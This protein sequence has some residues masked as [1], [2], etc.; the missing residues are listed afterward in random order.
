MQYK[1]SVLIPRSSLE[2]VGEVEVGK[3]YALQL[4]EDFLYQFVHIL[5]T[6]E[7]TFT[8]ETIYVGPLYL[9]DH[10][11]IA[12]A[13]FIKKKEITSS[14]FRQAIDL[15]EN[16]KNEI[17]SMEF[18]KTPHSGK[19][20]VGHYYYFT[21][22]PGN[23]IT[24]GYMSSFDSGGTPLIQAIEV[25]TFEN[26]I[27]SWRRGDFDKDSKVQCFEIDPQTYEKTKKLHDMLEVS[28]ITLMKSYLE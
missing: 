7:K 9:L 12:L 19:R 18:Y 5:E 28:L 25:D 1:R 16:C 3:Y 22:V 2:L 20:K 24:V 13:S 6:N 23:V 8:A 15:F 14:A 10:I 26:S 27:V 11:Y 21:N 17:L 4:S